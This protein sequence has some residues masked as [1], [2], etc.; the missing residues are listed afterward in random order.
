MAATSQLAWHTPSAA[1][2]LAAK[3]TIESLRRRCVEEGLEAAVEDRPQPHRPW[4]RNL[5]GVGVL[6]LSC[7]EARSRAHFNTYRSW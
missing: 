5:D 2:R 6:A 7:S 1:R 3:G 4:Q